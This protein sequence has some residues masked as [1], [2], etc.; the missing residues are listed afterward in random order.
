ME[1]IDKKSIKLAGSDVIFRGLFDHMPSG[2]AIYEVM[3]DGSK[4]S[5]YMIRGLNRK[6]L[7]LEG[8][9]LDEV[10][11]KSLFDLRPNI[12]EYGLI[13]VLKKVWETGET[14]YFP[15][16]IY[17]DDNFS[18]YYENYIFKLPSGEIVAIYN[19]VTD[20]KMNELALKKSQE[21]F[22]LAMRASNMGIWNW[23][24]KTNTLDWN[25]RMYE[26]YG[27]K[28]SDF[29]NIYEAW[30]NGLHP[31]DR[32]ENDKISEQARRGEREYDTQ[33]RIILPDGSIRFIKALGEV[34][35]D[36]KGNPERMTGINYD[37]TESKKAEE[38]ILQAQK[39]ESVGILAGGIAHDFN[40]ILFPIIGM[41]EMLLED[42]SPDSEE[43]GNAQEILA[44]G[45]R[46]SDLIKQ[47]LA[48]GRQS[49]N[50]MMPVH[51]HEIL[52]EVLTLCRSTIPANID[53]THEI[54]ENVYPVTANPT[55]MHQLTMNLI[56]NAYHAIDGTSGTIHL[57]FKEI[58]LGLDDVK[59]YLLAPGRYAL[60]SVSDTGSGI[61]KA[62]IDKIFEP[63]FT[64][65]EKG[66]GTGLG[67]A[68]VHGIVKEHQGDIKVY[69]ET[70]RGTTFNVYL[71]TMEAPGQTVSSFMEESHA[72]GTERILI[73][74]DEAVIANLERQM[75]ERLGYQIT[76]CVSSLD[77]LEVFRSDPDS[78]D[79]VLTDM[80]MPG[81]TGDELAGELLLIRPDIPI[82]LCTGFSE[83]ID[84]DTAITMGLK[85][86]LMK[87][88]VQQ[89]I[90]QTIRK[91]LNGSKDTRELS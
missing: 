21:N 50:K 13:P 9:T 6:G 83:K 40:N 19:D 34:A 14:A 5:D 48:L 88:V 33:F 63:Y 53:I 64:T 89:D 70:G 58:V 12:D 26:L 59:N 36:S 73:I 68:M 78:F 67:L 24:I 56:T 66:K 41:S 65:K 30:L 72:V 4:G 84:E 45:K 51:F 49:E 2:S 44:A 57:T 38:R 54:Q 43:Y 22:E 81:M 86:F 20:Q 8:K 87:P 39:L 55:Q 35:W 79:L 90:A 71:P 74:D 37:I 76:T 42:L 15:V 18:N 16:K 85:G 29:P 32:A 1:K 75:L 23:D 47:I 7:E 46:G 3:N 52:K 82:V 17:Q 28:K 31:D 77:A 11:G 25:D 60:L 80:S 27:I 69:S 91:I 10:I 62:L 61:P